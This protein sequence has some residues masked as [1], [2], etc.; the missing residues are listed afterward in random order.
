M[1][2]VSLA[3]MQVFFSTYIWPTHQKGTVLTSIQA[4]THPT[5]NDGRV[6]YFH[7]GWNTSYSQWWNILPLSSRLEHILLTMMKYFCT[8][9]HLGGNTSCSQ[10]WKGSA[11]TSIQAGTH[12]AHSDG[13]ACTHIWS[14]RKQSYNHIRMAPSSPRLSY[15]VTD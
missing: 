9:I 1:L 4:G 6:Q 8:Y 10:W 5:H 11:L 3:S 7:P 2:V 12:P 15:L 13:R 14:Y